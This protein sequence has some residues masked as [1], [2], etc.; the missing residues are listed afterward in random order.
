MMSSIT[1]ESAMIERANRLNIIENRTSSEIQLILNQ[2]N[3]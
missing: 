1:S 3:E 2:F